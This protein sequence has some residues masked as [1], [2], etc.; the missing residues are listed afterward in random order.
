MLNKDAAY[1]EDTVWRRK[2]DDLKAKIATEEA[3]MPVLEDEIKKQ[4]A[5]QKRLAGILG[6]TDDSH[7]TDIQHNE[8][9]P[10]FRDDGVTDRRQWWWVE[11]MGV[12]VDGCVCGWVGAWLDRH[13]QPPCIPK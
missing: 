9:E 10:A 5:E 1:R 4:Q 3:K 2:I 11:R 12:W 7:R 6:L 13:R 8:Q